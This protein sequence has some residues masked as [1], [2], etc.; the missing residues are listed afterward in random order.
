MSYLV[1]ASLISSAGFVC[2]SCDKML[3]QPYLE[4]VSPNLANGA[5]FR[6]SQLPFL[7][8]TQ[9]ESLPCAIPRQALLQSA[10]PLSAICPSDGIFRHLNAQW[11]G[12]LIHACPCRYSCSDN[13]NSRALCTET[14]QWPA[15]SYHQVPLNVDRLSGTFLLMP[16][17]PI[18]QLCAHPVLGLS[19]TLCPMARWYLIASDLHRCHNISFQPS[20]PTITPLV[21]DVVLKMMSI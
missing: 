21:R 16:R 2:V 8:V 11:E 6:V 12:W 20:L 10:H 5:P 14:R 19:A 13:E 7:H 4:M 3:S 9:A 1:P 17:T 15:F 18:H